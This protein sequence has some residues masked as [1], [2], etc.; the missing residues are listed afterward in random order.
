MRRIDPAAAEAAGR[1]HAPVPISASASWEPPSGRIIPA[2]A[3]LISL[4]ILAAAGCTPQPSAAPGRD[5]TEAG[6]PQVSAV[7]TA[8]LTRAAAAT[9]SP[10]P[11]TPAPTSAPAF[12]AEP[13]APPT[14]SPT[15]TATVPPTHAPA[16]TPAATLGAGS[17]LTNADGAVYV[18]VPAGEFLM[19]SADDDGQASGD[20]KP[21]HVVVLDAYWVGRT[22]V[23]NAQYASCMAAGTCTESGCASDVDFDGAGKPVV[24]VDWDQ[25]SAYCAWTGGRLPTEAEW[26][27]AARGTDGRIY[28]WGNEFD[29]TR[30]NYCD[31]T[32]S[33]DWRDLGAGDGYPFTAPVGSYR[34]G[35]SPYGALDMAGNAWEWVA[36]WYGDSYYV[37]SPPTNPQGPASGSLRVLRGGSWFTTAEVAR[38]ASRLARAPDLQ[39]GL[40][41]FRCVR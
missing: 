33:Y 16:S 41:G 15:S 21:Q 22:E 5:A 23:T 28:P 13:T 39:L 18:Y 8:Y 19:G 3:I 4:A 30:L 6:S 29:G 14:L 40:I 26:E 2:A 11:P 25:A 31:R 24:C 7:A 34:A 36:D 20:E 1:Q 32:C 10:L 9:A 27:K 12:T 17:L 35:A 38:A 37:D